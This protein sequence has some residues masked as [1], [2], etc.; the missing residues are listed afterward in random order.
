MTTLQLRAQN[1]DPQ[2]IAVLL[3][4]AFPVQPIGIKTHLKGTCL[5]LRL[6][7][8]ESLP[9]S[10]VLTFL[11]QWLSKLNPSGIHEIQVQAQSAGEVASSWQA[12][13]SLISL[14]STAEANIAIQNTA[15]PEQTPPQ[16][17]V[18]HPPATAKIQHSADE[19]AVYYRQLNL[20]PG[21]TLEAVNG[22]YFAL[23]AQLR[24]Q[25][26]SAK[27][28]EITHAHQTLK[29][30]LQLQASQTA[31]TEIAQRQ[32]TARLSHLLQEQGLKAQI[33]LAD[34]KLQ[35]GIPAVQHPTPRKPV[36]TIY[37]LLSTLDLTDLQLDT[38]K[39]VCVYGLKAPK[40]AAWKQQFAM[41]QR[42]LSKE[43]TDLL[44][45][46]NR[47]SSAIIFPLLSVLAIGLNMMP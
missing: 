18:N 1:G 8:F 9:Q 36:A 40:Q 41:P 12:S 3:Q 23:K 46:Q 35:I 4:A 19:L 25:G 17:V 38:V 31:E 20:D 14:N 39:T 44:S 26:N 27:L 43:D 11:E 15:Q 5:I 2:A 7:S 24:H 21:A 22:A 10:S 42:G 47:Y 6:Q 16:K 32:P 37:T 34:R 30:H 13:L 45:F 29:S 33:R 28:A